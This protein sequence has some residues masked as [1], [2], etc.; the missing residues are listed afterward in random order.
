MAVVAR[1]AGLANL[2]YP[3]PR[4][5]RPGLYTNALFHLVWGR[6][7]GKSK[8]VFPEKHSFKWLR[9]SALTCRRDKWT[10]WCPGDPLVLK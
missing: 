5:L 2:L 7:Y 8:G 1:F 9:P 10:T 3:V 4:R 6:R